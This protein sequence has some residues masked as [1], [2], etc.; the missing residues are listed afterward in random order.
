MVRLIQ[1]LNSKDIEELC[2]V[3]KILELFLKLPEEFF[4]KNHLIA[5]I[6]S[7]I[8]KVEVFT[9]DVRGSALQVLRNIFDATSSAFPLSKFLPSKL[10]YIL[11]ESNLNL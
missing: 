5:S 7:V 2:I 6:L 10:A 1:L 4:T 11:I 3:P 9:I 8:L